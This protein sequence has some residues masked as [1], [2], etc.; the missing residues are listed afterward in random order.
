[1]AVRR[2]DGCCI[3]ANEWTGELQQVGR[4][5]GFVYANGGVRVDVLSAPLK[6]S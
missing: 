3:A 5:D 2:E 6:P 4:C 1:M